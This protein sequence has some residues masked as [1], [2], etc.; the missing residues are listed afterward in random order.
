MKW[1]KWPAR[2]SCSGFACRVECTAK[3]TCCVERFTYQRDI[4]HVSAVDS[5]WKEENPLS[6]TFKASRSDYFTIRRGWRA[7]GASVELPC[8]TMF[9]LKSD[10]SWREGLKS[11]ACLHMKKMFSSTDRTAASAANLL[12]VSFLFLLHPLKDVTGSVIFRPDEKTVQVGGFHDRSDG[13]QTWILCRPAASHRYRTVS[14]NNLS[15]SISSVVLARLAFHPP[16][17]YRLESGRYKHRT[18][19]LKSCVFG[20]SEASLGLF[21]DC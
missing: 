7:I 19:G 11:L 9:Y 12:A 2:D 17:G 14:L 5:V 6:I 8:A 21:D 15:M 4:F 3:P 20:I 13:F 16:T 1:N 10:Q 18:W